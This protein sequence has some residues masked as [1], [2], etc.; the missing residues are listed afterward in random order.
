DDA[1]LVILVGGLEGDGEDSAEVRVAVERFDALSQSERGVKLIAI[2]V[3]NPAGVPL[4]FPPSGTAYR[5][6]AEANTLWRFIGAH[7][8]DLVL[9]AGEETF[10]LD[11][12]LANE[13]VALV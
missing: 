11:D 1:P 4:E 8:P 6:N 7:G 5:E 13:P 10:G 3:A 9:I 2:P 12:A